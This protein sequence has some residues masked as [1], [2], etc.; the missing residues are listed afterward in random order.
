M[1]SGF[2]PLGSEVPISS[3]CYGGAWLTPRRRRCPVSNL[4]TYTSLLGRVS[5][6]SLAAFEV[7]RIPAPSG[8]LGAS[9]CSVKVVMELALVERVGR[10]PAEM[11]ID[12]VSSTYA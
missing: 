1:V 3:G 4:N 8:S 10:L 11:R 12:V 6:H 5:S 9:C 7:S 2:V